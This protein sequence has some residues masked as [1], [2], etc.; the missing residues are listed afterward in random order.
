MNLGQR[1]KVYAC[2]YPTDMRGSYDTLAQKTKKILKKDPWSGHLFL[3]VNRRKTSCKCLYYD[4]TGFIILAKR[5]DQGTFSCFN[6]LYKKE[7]VLSS[8]EFSLFLEGAQINKRFIE[9]PAKRKRH[10][11]RYLQ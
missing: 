9:S 11:F 7:L 6:P 4:G 8:S 2:K 1:I 3:F 5:L 10:S